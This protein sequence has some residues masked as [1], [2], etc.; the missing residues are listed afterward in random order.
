MWSV[1]G[2]LHGEHQSASRS[3][4]VPAGLPSGCHC[5]AGVATHT[6]TPYRQER[7]LLT[8]WKHPNWD[9][10]WTQHE[11]RRTAQWCMARQEFLR[12]C[13]NGFCA[14]NGTEQGMMIM[15]GLRGLINSLGGL[16]WCWL[17]PLCI[18]WSLFNIFSY[19]LVWRLTQ[20]YIRQ[21]F[22]MSPFTNI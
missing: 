8:L 17:F 14:M 18:I 4:S 2:A 21:Y 3:S 20:P 10:Q 16:C 7:G 1:T 6:Q 22:E 12:V 5:T 13:F 9:D 15:L 19:C 11:W